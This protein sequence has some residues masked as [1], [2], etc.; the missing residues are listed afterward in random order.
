MYR[1]EEARKRRGA[2]RRWGGVVAVL[3]LAGSA[4]ACTMPLDVDDRAATIHVGSREV[5]V[6]TLGDVLAVGAEVR[7][8]NGQLLTRPDIRWELS[9]GGILEPIAGGSFRVIGEGRVTIAAVWRRDPSVR[10]GVTVTVDPGF[11]ARACIVRLD[12]STGQTARECTEQRLTVHVAPIPAQE[13]AAAFAS[14]DAP[15]LDEVLARGAA[16]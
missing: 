8:A 10:A 6:R 5:Q 12:A 13:I 9:S 2:G 7:S 1:N 14:G 11:L 15:R 3:W 4:A 16:E